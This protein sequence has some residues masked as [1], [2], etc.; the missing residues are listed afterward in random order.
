M[1]SPAGPGRRG[2]P[3]FGDSTAPVD[4][5]EPD[6]LS[7]VELDPDPAPVSEVEP[8]L[9]SVEVPESELGADPEDVSGTE[10]VVVVPDVPWWW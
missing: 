10:V 8:E 3:T 6:P 4:A 2:H 1:S 7:D 9:E 5:L